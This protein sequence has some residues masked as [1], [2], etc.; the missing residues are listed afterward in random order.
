MEKN[1][2]VFCVIMIIYNIKAVKKAREKVN[3]QSRIY[4]TAA[5]SEMKKMGAFP[6]QGG[7]TPD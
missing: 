6:Y 1:T 4:V 5:W 2:C 3:F 7:M